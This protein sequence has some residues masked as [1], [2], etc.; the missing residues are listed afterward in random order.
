MALE[1]SC[2][3]EY[4]DEW[5]KEAGQCHYSY[6]RFFDLTWSAKGTH[7]TASFYYKFG[8]GTY[9]TVMTFSHTSSNSST[10][11]QY[12]KRLTFSK[13]PLDSVGAGVLTVKITAVDFLN[14][15]VSKEE[16]ITFQPVLPPS[17]DDLHVTLTRHSADDI[18]CSWF[19][20]EDPLEGIGPSV[21]G[22]CVELFYKPSGGSWAQI[23]NLAFAGFDLIKSDYY[24]TD[25]SYEAYINHPDACYFYFNPRAFG[26]QKDDSFKF[27]VYPYVVYG[28]YYSGSS[29]EPG[30]LLTS[31]GDEA[32]QGFTLGTVRVKKSETDWVEGQVWVCAADSDSPTGFKW[33]EADSIYAK[34]A[35]GWKESIS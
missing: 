12:S 2:S 17:S 14:R 24:T 21:A 6:N 31:D 18:E 22:Y 11:S 35:D 5:I 8:N 30:T 28:S 27:R 9:K 10:V 1:L 23:K 3:A 32:S 13:L 7:K 20:P 16:T 4:K 15:T 29:V 26:I 33:K 19:R 25:S 34:T